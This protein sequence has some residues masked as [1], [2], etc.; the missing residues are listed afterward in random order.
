MGISLNDLFFVFEKNQVVLLE[1][2]FW[3]QEFVP[4]NDSTF[5]HISLGGM[6]LF[7]CLWSCFHCLSFFWFVLGK[8]C[9]FLFPYDISDPSHIY[10]RIELS[11]KIAAVALVVAVVVNYHHHHPLYKC[12]TLMVE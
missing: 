6:C 7:I 10:L 4:L 8:C 9:D 1:T 11:S 5:F 12:L 3:R 2:I